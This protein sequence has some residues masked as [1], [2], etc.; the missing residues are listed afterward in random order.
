MYFSRRKDETSQTTATSTNLHSG[1]LPNKNKLTR[2]QLPCLRCTLHQPMCLLVFVYTCLHVY[3]YLRIPYI[4][5]HFCQANKTNFNSINCMWLTKE[6]EQTKE[7]T[8][9]QP[10]EPYN[11]HPQLSIRCV[12]RTRRR[13]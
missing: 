6:I 11:M 13:R 5:N 8:T 2:L 3:T 4:F 12:L 10:S 7:I 9:R 1:Y